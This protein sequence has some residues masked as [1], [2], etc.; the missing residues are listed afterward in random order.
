MVRNCLGGSLAL[1][2]WYALTCLLPVILNEIKSITQ[3][4]VRRS[5]A[6][7]VSTVP[8]VTLA[9]PV[10]C[11]GSASSSTRPPER[12]W[13]TA[14]RKTISSITM[15]PVRLFFLSSPESLVFRPR[16]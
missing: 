4:D 6:I 8:L 12:S 2:P 1:L 10:A 9:D 14:S 11:S 3:G 5:P 16:R 13:I 7:V 15:S